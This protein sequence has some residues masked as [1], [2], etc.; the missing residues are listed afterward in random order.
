MAATAE[1]VTLGADETAPAV[2]EGLLVAAVDARAPGMT[3][4]DVVR[5]GA[6]A[7]PVASAGPGDAVASPGTMEGDEA[8]ARLPA[9]SGVTLVVSVVDGPSATDSAA[10]SAGET[11]IGPAVTATE[12]ATAAAASAVTP[13]ETAPGDAVGA[14]GDAVLAAVAGVACTLAAWC[15]TTSSGLLLAESVE[16]KVALND[17]FLF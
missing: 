14:D 6:P 12:A 3:C 13:I 8:R 1:P 15:S 17:V 9:P 10:A 2:T 7:T 16:L 5:D 11:D 4:T